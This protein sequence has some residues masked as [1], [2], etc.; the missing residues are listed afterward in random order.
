LGTDRCTKP[1]NSFC[2]M[3]FFMAHHSLLLRYLPDL[4]ALRNTLGASID[5]AGKPTN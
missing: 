1:A 3:L 5:R 2:S 4:K